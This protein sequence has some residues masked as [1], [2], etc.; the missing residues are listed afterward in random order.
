ME[1]R[2]ETNRFTLVYH[3]NNSYKYKG[4]FSNDDFVKYVSECGHFF[5]GIKLEDSGDC[6]M[7]YFGGT[8][9]VDRYFELSS[10]MYLDTEYIYVDF[11]RDDVSMVAKDYDHT[12]GVIT[13]HPDFDLNAFFFG[14][15]DGDAVQRNESHVE[16][17]AGYGDL[18]GRMNPHGIHVVDDDVTVFHDV[19]AKLVFDGRDVYILRGKEK[20]YT[21]DVYSIAFY[22]DIYSMYTVMDIFPSDLKR[23]FERGF[24]KE[25]I[26]Q[27]IAHSES[28]R[29]Y[30]Q[31]FHIAENR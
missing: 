15:W 11:P 18:T 23:L 31:S 6:G 29:V 21:S 20:L 26:L 17:R 30:Y 12:I 19:W 5:D 24:Q 9:T 4:S 13:S 3:L 2:R 14:K 1:K 8:Y 10:E 25:D 28:I 27:A 7:K 22:D 16:T